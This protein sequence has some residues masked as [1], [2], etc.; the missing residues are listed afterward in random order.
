MR[1][2]E[3]ILLLQ[4]KA[5][6]E[7]VVVGIAGPNDDVCSCYGFATGFVDQEESPFEF[8]ETRTSKC[9]VPAVML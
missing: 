4:E 7:A 8:S 3:L 6:P 9:A 1:V 5:D 2:R